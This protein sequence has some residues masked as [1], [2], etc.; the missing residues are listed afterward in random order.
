MARNCKMS[1]AVDVRDM[2]RVKV[3]GNVFDTIVCRLTYRS[4]T[5]YMVSVG[6]YNLSG[7]GM[8]VAHRSCSLGKLSKRRCKS[9]DNA[10]VDTAKSMVGNM[11]RDICGELGFDWR[12]SVD[13]V[14]VSVAFKW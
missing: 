3:D 7:R 13:H 8:S 11:F 5:G 2:V 12:D 9:D 14:R 1:S 6:A 10:M 4:D